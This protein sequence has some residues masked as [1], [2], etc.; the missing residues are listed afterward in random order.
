MLWQSIT[1]I[2]SQNTLLQFTVQDWSHMRKDQRNK[3]HRQL[4]KQAYPEVY[5][6]KKPKSTKDIFEMLS[7]VVSG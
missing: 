4:H 7:G 3:V 2:E 5:E 1:R 6:S